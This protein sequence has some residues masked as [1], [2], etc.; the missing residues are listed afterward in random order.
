M[1]ASEV[2]VILDSSD[3][4]VKFGNVPVGGAFEYNG[5]YYIRV[6]PRIVHGKLVYPHSGM[7]VYSPKANTDGATDEELYT[8]KAFDLAE[9]VIPH[10]STLNIEV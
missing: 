10:D 4:K 9:N 6:A 2:N 3:K 8:L 7:K 1:A 5:S